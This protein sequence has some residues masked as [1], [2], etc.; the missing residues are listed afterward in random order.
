MNYENMSKEEL[1]ELLKLK[2]LQIGDLIDISSLDDLT[3]VLNRRAGIEK[4]NE[5]YRYS[6][7]NGEDISI[8]FADL[9]NLK[10]IN[11]TWGH[12]SGDEALINISYII[13]KNIR[14]EDFIFR[15]G[16]DEFVI[17]FPNTSTEKV[18]KVLKRICRNLRESNVDSKYEL[19]LSYGLCSCK[20]FGKYNISFDDFLNNADYEMYKNKNKNKNNNLI[21]VE[22]QRITE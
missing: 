4:F 13:K 10:M 15:F 9:D 17:I 3:K 5:L 20:E 16:G 6:L 19:G 2:D 1:I 11:D 7:I 8:C 22:C 14:K 21:M 12:K 18:D